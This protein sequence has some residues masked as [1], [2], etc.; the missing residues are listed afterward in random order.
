[1]K[2]YGFIRVAAA[3]PS[4]KPADVNGNVD[5]ICR[6]I[7]EASG[8]GVSL[9][10]FPELCVTG[11]TCGDLFGQN[12]LLEAAE[13]GVARIMEASR[14]K[15]MT[16]VAGAPV[17]YC[18]RLYNC[19]IVIRN[20]NIKGIVPKIHLP[21]YNEFY[22]SRWFSPGTDF[23]DGHSDGRAAFMFNGKDYVESAECYITNDGIVHLDIVPIKPVMRVFD[24]TGSYYLNRQGKRMAANANIFID[25]PVVTGNFT[26]YTEP[27]K[28]L[29]MLEYIEKDEFLRNLV[30]QVEVKDTN[31]IFIVPNIVGHIIN[32][33]T[34]DHFQSKFAKLMRMYKEVMPVKGWETYDTINLK[35]DHQIVATKRNKKSRL[36]IETY[37][38]TTEEEAPT[39]EMVE[40]SEK[41]KTT[42][43]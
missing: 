32:M 38:P 34:T 27:L 24:S 1:M 17:R 18:G 36:S 33:G 14:G 5:S 3:R 20:G 43:N 8:T 29:P 13:K 28:L 23:L 6:L 25:L 30:T 35:W 39:L 12:A 2:D 7:G 26:N 42:D 10:V 4:V 21:S 19:A 37:D 22:E 16:I 31:N 15:E 9:V 40:K 11:Y 41:K